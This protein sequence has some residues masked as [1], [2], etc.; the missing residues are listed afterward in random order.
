MYLGID[1]GTSN[2]A[3]AGASAGQVRIFK[4]PE[5]TDTMP[6]VIYRDRRGNQRV[7]V[8]AFDQA[9]LAPD[10]A[11]EGFKRLMG[12]DTPLRFAST[13]D[14]VTPEQASTEILKAL[15]GQALVEAGSDAVTG[16]VVTIPAAFTQLQSEATLAAAR[17]AGLDRVAL[18]QEPVAAALASMAGARDRNG[19]FLVYDLGGGTFDAALVH[20][21]DGDVTVLA[22]EG[23]NSLG[24]RDLDR[25][26]MDSVAMPWLKRTFDLPPGFAVDP[27]YSRLVRMARRAAE[28]AKI[29]LSTGES[30]TINASD[31]EIRLADLQGEPIYLDVPFTRSEFEAMAEDL[32]ARSIACCRQMLSDVG[33]RNEDVSRVVLIGGPTKIPYLRRRIQ[34]ELGIEVEDAARVDP[35]T[36]VATG[37]AIYC[38]GRDWSGK[39]SLPKATR[40]TESAGDAIRVTFDYEARTAA[41][42]AW[43]TISQVAGAAGT[44]ILVES[45][46][47]WSTGRKKLSGPLTVNLPLGQMGTNEFRA[48]VFDPRGRPVADASRIITVER[49]LA[50]T[51]GVPATHIVAA[52]ILDDRG[53]NILD[54]M[55]QKG[56][57]LPATGVVKY[58]LAS[59]LRAGSSETIRVEVY[60][61]SNA[62]VTDPHLNL[63]VGEFRLRADDLPPSTALRKGDE[64][65]VHWAMDEGQVITAEIE[66]PLAQ[67]R[68]DSTNFY[69]W[70]IARQDF[71]GEEGAK[72]AATHLDQAQREMDDAEETVPFAQ[73]GQLAAIRKRLD[74]YTDL[75]RGTLEPDTRRT[76][77]EEVRLLRQDIAQV[78]QHPDARRD[79]LR[80]RL[81]AQRDFYDRDI[82]D[83]AT[84]DQAAEVDALLRNATATIDHSEDFRTASEL[85]RRVKSL[86]W[87]H[88]IQQ[89]RFCAGQFMLERNNRHLASDRAAF[90]RS[91]AQGE[92]ALAES[93][94]PAVRRAYIEIILGQV[95]VGSDINGPERASLMRM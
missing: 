15:V 57:M 72:L 85:I 52:K 32:V 43:L 4:T 42:T 88:G 19:I 27:A 89:D 79:L 78:T 86:Y 20:A 26:I 12:T 2:S 30:T 1:L 59:P 74:G 56:T 7:G 71:S 31:D 16:A 18:L 82:R 58:R 55:V 37:A 33:Y 29:A 70:Q 69:N 49:L 73:A 34:E 90:D 66:I 6:S 75:L 67:Q 13:G 39:G 92:K 76:A 62:L 38:E 21:I 65:H 87:I 47:G 10:N 51:G 11:V 64:V 60:E 25:R 77:V 80:R 14:M 46:L 95:S 45:F 35:M 50:S 28:T 48:T 54:V 8:R 53:N 91:V 5:G 44:E 61:V 22:H 68:F 9:G 84:P 23:V 36:A 83:G 41:E 93:D 24:G 63:L 40:L 94:F 3:I 17:G 81:A